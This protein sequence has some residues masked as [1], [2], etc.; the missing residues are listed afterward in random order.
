LR[1]SFQGR[2]LAITEPVAERW[3]VLDGKCQLQGM[4]L[5]A[6]DGLIAAAA[7]EH[8]P[9]RERLRRPGRRYF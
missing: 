6:A 7:L 8:D 2:I 3:G 9:E 5:N 4:P 1:P